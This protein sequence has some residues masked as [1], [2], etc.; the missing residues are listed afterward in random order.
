MRTGRS[1]VR[2]KGRKWG[3]VGSFVLNGEARRSGDA[4]F[5]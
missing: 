1:E 4:P 3:E 2:I 5:E